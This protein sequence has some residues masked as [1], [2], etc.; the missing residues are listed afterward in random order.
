MSTLKGRRTT[1]SCH[2]TRSP[3]SPPIKRR[4]CSMY[5]MD[6]TP[7]P[8]NRAWPSL[9][10]LHYTLG[11]LSIPDNPT[12]IHSVSIFPNKIKW[13]ED[14]CMWADSVEDSFFHACRWLDLCCHNGIIFNPD[15]FQFWADSMEF[16]SFEI[17]L[18]SIKPCQRFWQII[19]DFPTPRNITDIR[20]CFG[21]VNQAS[22]CTSLTD[23]MK[24]FR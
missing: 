24:P 13:I 15:K 5:G 2:F 19:T 11:P 16:A 4:L 20:S 8:H 23:E 1:F 3:T 9:H 21:L 12:G 6:T 17:A 22:Y 14:T 18:D 10:H 7:Y